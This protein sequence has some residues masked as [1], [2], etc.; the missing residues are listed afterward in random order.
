MFWLHV[1]DPRSTAHAVPQRTQIRG[2]LGAITHGYA[3]VRQH[4]PKRLHT[5]QA[6]LQVLP[7]GDGVDQ[8]VDD[9]WPTA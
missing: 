9:Y 6:D 3:T 4:R 8:S 1:R 2:P 7:G 5:L